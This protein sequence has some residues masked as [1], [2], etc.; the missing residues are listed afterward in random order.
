MLLKRPFDLRIADWMIRKLKRYKQIRKQGMVENAWN[1]LFKK[2]DHFIHQLED[3]L[4]II[5][6]KDS[7]LCRYIYNGFEDAEITFI[8]KFLQEGDT[9][10]DIGSNIGIM[11][12]YA[13]EKVGPQGKVIA[14]EPTP[15]TFKRLKENC[16]L[17]GFYHVHSEN[18]GL[19]DSKGIMKLNIIGNGRDGWNTFA[20][21]PHEK[22]DSVIDVKVNTLDNY[23][24][25][26]NINLTNLSFIKIDVEGWE[27]PVIK[28][29]LKTI[30]N[31]SNSNIVLMVEFTE[32]NCKAAGFDISYLYDLVVEQGYTW[33]IYDKENNRLQYDAKRSQYPYVN[34]FAVKNIENINKKLAP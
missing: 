28:G 20:T 32:A 26:N 5:L 13:A 23:I 19:S 17:N 33:C 6:Y 30:C 15:E 21:S 7:I 25:A 4:K 18:I 31:Y 34:L 8:K 16:V 9:F 29:A 14:F 24:T 12:L 27:I 11:S 10:I 3:H 22:F 1:S 2:E